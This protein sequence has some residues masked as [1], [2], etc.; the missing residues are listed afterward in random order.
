MQLNGMYHPAD[1]GNF[2]IDA[3]FGQL[4]SAINPAKLECV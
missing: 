1:N 3:H 4:I 2:I